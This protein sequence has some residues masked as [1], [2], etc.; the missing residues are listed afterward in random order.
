VT[1]LVVTARA[2]DESATLDFIHGFGETFLG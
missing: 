2:T 1:S